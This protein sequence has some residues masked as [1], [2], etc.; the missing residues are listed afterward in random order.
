MPQLSGGGDRRAAHSPTLQRL[1]VC[2]TRLSRA[3]TCPASREG[4]DRRQPPP[5]AELQAGVTLGL[6]ALGWLHGVV[7]RVAQLRLLSQSCPCFNQ[8]PLGI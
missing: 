8:C 6:P 7:I 3:S 5:W 1:L 2:C 4:L